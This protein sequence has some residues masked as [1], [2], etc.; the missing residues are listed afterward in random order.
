MIY[1]AH[2][3][4]T[5][6][7]QTGPRTV[8][9][10][11]GSPRSPSEHGRDKFNAF[12]YNSEE[13]QQLWQS[14]PDGVDIVVTH[15][16]PNMHCD[17]QSDGLHMGC[18]HLRRSLWRVRPRLAV[19]GHIHEARGYDRV[20]WD[21]HSGD[22]EAAELKSTSGIDN[23]GSSKRQFRIDLTSKSASPLDHSGDTETGKKETCIINAAIM[24][25]SWPYQTSKMFNK[26]I[27]VDIDLPTWEDDIA[28]I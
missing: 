9:S 26:P 27:V 16:P 8:F 28:P 24:A 25:S 22:E 23:T 12:C 11:F 17:I 13:G 6:Q 15:T 19:S 7:L 21:L 10:V 3:M 18:D 2:E 1:L 14:I 5:I 20:L 4:K